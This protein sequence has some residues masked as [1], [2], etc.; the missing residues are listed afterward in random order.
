MLGVQQVNPS[1]PDQ[2]WQIASQK[3][4]APDN[5]LGT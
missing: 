4:W 3:M 5:Y 1:P 2:L